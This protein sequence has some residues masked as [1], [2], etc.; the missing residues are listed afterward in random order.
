[1]LSNI[2]GYNIQIFNYGDCKRDFTY[3][4][5]IVEENLHAKSLKSYC[6]K[7]RPEIALRTSMS[8]YRK[9]D[10]L[11]NVPFYAISAFTISPAL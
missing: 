3:V 7:Y 1:L 2:F 6:E 10:W 11:T 5:D 8:N 9:Q 4:D